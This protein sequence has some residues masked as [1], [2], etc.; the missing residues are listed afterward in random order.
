MTRKDYQL[1]ASIIKSEAEAWKPNSTQAVM[2][3]QFAKAFA[4]KLAED[5]PRFDASRFF[6]ACE[7]TA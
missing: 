1:I 5:N 4:Q 6:K 2:C 3:D 7:P